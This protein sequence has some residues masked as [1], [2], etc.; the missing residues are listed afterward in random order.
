MKTAW[1]DHA[2]AAWANSLV[3]RRHSIAC[4]I[5]SWY[6]DASGCVE[7]SAPEC[8]IRYAVEPQVGRGIRFHDDGNSAGASSM[9]SSDCG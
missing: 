9:G 5:A 8:L 2:V 4:P 1:C 3:G 6:A 7:M